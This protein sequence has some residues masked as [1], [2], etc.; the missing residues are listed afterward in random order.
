MENSSSIGMHLACAFHPMPQSR[1]MHRLHPSPRP[2]SRVQSLDPL[3]HCLDSLVHLSLKRVMAAE[4]VQEAANSFFQTFSTALADRDTTRIS[5]LYHPHAIVVL[6][7][8]DGS[9][10]RVY[11]GGERGVLRV[12]NWGGSGLEYTSVS[13]FATSPTGLHAH[14][15]GRWEN[16]D[17]VSHAVHLHVF[18]VN[19]GATQTV[20]WECVF[21]CLTLLSPP[22]LLEPILAPSSSHPPLINVNDG[23]ESDAGEDEVGGKKQEEEKEKEEGWPTLMNALVMEGEGVDR[24]DLPHFIGSLG[25]RVLRIYTRPEG[26]G[27]GAKVVI[28]FGDD[29][30]CDA[31]YG[32]RALTRSLESVCVCV[33][34]GC[35][36]SPR[37]GWLGVF[38]TGRANAGEEGKK[39]GEGGGGVA[40]RKGGPN[41][42]PEGVR[43]CRP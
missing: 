31:V 22:I 8:E 27:L 34:S 7:H 43:K 23:V 21:D 17:K 9:P 24:K 32:M 37:P 13:S 18:P 1:S 25:A 28:V 5:R 4:W 35:G 19:T 2:E 12:S 15:V 3:T 41:Y 26:V 33:S 20:A 38:G 39:N 36:C 14:A 6:A 40:R 16:G 29:E 11:C 42:R 30:Q 10:Q